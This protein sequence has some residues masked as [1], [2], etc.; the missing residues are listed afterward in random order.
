V[1][2]IVG[3]VGILIFIIKFAK[4]GKKYNSAYDDENVDDELN[5]RKL[6]AKQAGKEFVSNDESKEKRSSDSKETQII[7]TSDQDDE[8]ALKG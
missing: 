8:E 2:G 6:D 1:L 4:R 3:S 5:K 7:K